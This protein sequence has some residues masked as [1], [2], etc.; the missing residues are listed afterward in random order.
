MDTS[1]LICGASQWTG[2]YMITISVM[3]ELRNR[4]DLVVKW[5]ITFGY[6]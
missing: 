3:K 6:L 1:P 2:F 5:D 4:A